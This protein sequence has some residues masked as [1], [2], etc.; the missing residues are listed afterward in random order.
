MPGEPIKMRPLGI[1]TIYDRAVQALWASALKAYAENI[2]TNDSHGFRAGRSTWT[3]IAQLKGVLMYKPYPR[4]LLRVD[5][6]GFFDNISHEWLI[7][8]VPLPERIIIE[9]LTAGVKVKGKVLPTTRGVPQGGVISPMLANLVLDGVEQHI[10]EALRKVNVSESLISAFR[11]VR[12]AD[13]FILT[14]PKS[15]KIGWAW[16]IARKA[17]GEFLAVR[18]LTLHPTKTKS[19]DVDLESFDFL[20]VNVRVE[21]VSGSDYPYFRTYITKEAETKVLNKVRELC[22]QINLNHSGLLTR[23]NSVLRGWSN[24][25]LPTQCTDAFIR[26]DYVTWH[27][28]L[29]YIL[30]KHSGLSVKSLLNTTTEKRGNSL[31]FIAWAMFPGDKVKRKIVLYR[32]ASQGLSQRSRDAMAKI[33]VALDKATGKVNAENKGQSVTTSNSPKR[34]LLKIDNSVTH[35]VPMTFREALKKRRAESATKGNKL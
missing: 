25:Y 28:V 5:I 19:V 15:P 20:G 26:V 6:Q 33:N 23:L 22:R 10:Q 7:K 31:D 12:Y 1:P 8:N 18:G 17:L 27:A 30:K 13:D 14:G 32:L 9:F 35:K 2:A 21:R 16:K 11:V 3:A 34:S 24:Y 29:R 4:I